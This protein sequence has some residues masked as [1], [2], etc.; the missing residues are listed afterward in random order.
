MRTGGSIE[1]V[2]M[3]DDYA[4]N[5]CEDRP[6]QAPLEEQVDQLRREVRELR[7]IM[8]DLMKHE[9]GTRGVMVPIGTQL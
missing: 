3:Q 1:E 9:H 5:Q 2:N 8:H 7:K 6:K 4:V